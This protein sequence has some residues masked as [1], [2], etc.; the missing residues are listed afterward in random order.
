MATSGVAERAQYFLAQCREAFDEGSSDG[1][2][3]SSPLPL[4][5]R[6]LKHGLGAVGIF[7]RDSV[8]FRSFE[9]D[10][11]DAELWQRDK[12][13]LIAET[14][15]AILNTPIRAH[16]AWLKQRLEGKLIEVNRR[17]EAGKNRHFQI[18]RHGRNVH[19]TLQG[20]PASE[21][22][23]HPVFE[24]LNQ[25]EIVDVLRF[26]DRECGFLGT[27]EHV[28]GRYARQ[29]PQPDILLACLTAWSTNLRTGATAHVVLFSSNRELPYEQVVDCYRLR[30]QL[31]FNFLD[32]RPSFPA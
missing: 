11:I 2:L 32:V 15:L 4:I 20:L 8:R 17:I 26:V 19:W 1:T 18:K 24:T 12:Q 28:L 5:Y 16:L 10:L 23:N 21:P 7:C 25:T 29:K 30:F 6:F 27:F 3:S 22:A 13:R 31:E 9:D 14:D